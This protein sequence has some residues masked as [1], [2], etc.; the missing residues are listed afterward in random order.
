M[1]LNLHICPRSFNS[2]A[3]ICFKKIKSKVFDNA[4]P[5]NPCMEHIDWRNSHSLVLLC[6]PNCE[7]ST[8]KRLFIQNCYRSHNICSFC[9][10]RPENYACTFVWTFW[11][12]IRQNCM[13][14]KPCFSIL[15]RICLN[16]FKCFVPHC[17]S[18]LQIPQLQVFVYRTFW[19]A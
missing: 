5:R 11:N 2:R 17:C 13:S 10:E 14:N 18:Y 1:F 16:L 3:N 15:L 8:V 19:F 7:Q 6:R 12:G 4:I 9:K